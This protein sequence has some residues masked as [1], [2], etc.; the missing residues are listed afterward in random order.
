MLYLLQPSQMPELRDVSYYY[1]H[2]LS[3]NV[4]KQTCVYSHVCVQAH[5]CHEEGGRVRGHIQESPSPSTLF[6][7]RSFVCS[8]IVA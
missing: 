4:K 1:I 5:M 8:F 3:M 7:T 2:L 6:E